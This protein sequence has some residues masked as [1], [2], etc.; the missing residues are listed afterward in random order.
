MSQIKNT[1][2]LAVSARLFD[3]NAW[4]NKFASSIVVVYIIFIPEERR[5]SERADGDGALPLLRFWDAVVIDDDSRC[6]F[7]AESSGGINLPYEN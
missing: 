1:I 6:L 3:G 2:H 4:R 5:A 7:Y